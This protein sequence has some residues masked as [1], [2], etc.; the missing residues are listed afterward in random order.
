LITFIALAMQS[1]G[2]VKKNGDPAVGFSFTTM[3]LLVKDFLA[4][5][6]VT[7]L[8]HPPYSPDFS[9][10]DFYMFPRLI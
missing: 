6:N 4:K 1:E 8:E 7:T 10:A 3:Y 2:K 9:P 5:N